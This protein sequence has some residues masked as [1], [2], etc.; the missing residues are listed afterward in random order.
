MTLVAVGLGWAMAGRVLRPVHAVSGTARRLSQRNLHERIPV[1]GPH[2]EMR[3]LAETFNDMLSRLER[4]FQAQRRFAANASHEP[5][6]PMTTQR[7]L[8]E[9]AAASREAGPEVTELADGLRAQL[10]RQQR[11][12]DGLLA[13][14]CGEHGVTEVVPVDLGDLVREHLDPAPA[15]VTV[16]PRLAPAV[17]PGDPVLLDLLVGYLV[18][19][20]VKH[21]VHDGQVWSAPARTGST[22]RTPGRRSG[23]NGYASCWS[24]SGAVSA[25]G[26]GRAGAGDRGGGGHRARGGWNC[27]RARAAASPLPSRSPRPTPSTIGLARTRQP[28]DQQDPVTRGRWS[29]GLA[30]TASPA[31]PRSPAPPP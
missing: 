19:N 23:R 3:E 6:G 28:H 12:V 24:R 1:H 4:A 11:L 9:V 14:A 18:R 2:D 8:V 15:G 16:H 10:D 20:A 25:T 31:P 29:A 26:C 27:S 13:L 5:R 17:V 21:N 30:G 7:A 22:W